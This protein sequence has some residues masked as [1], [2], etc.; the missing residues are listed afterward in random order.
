MS[1]TTVAIVGGG[2]S[3]LVAAISAKRMGAKVTILERNPRVGKKILA[4]GNGRCNLTN[5]NADVPCYNGENP[6]FIYSAFSQFSVERSLEFFE[7]LGIE[8]K[9]EEEGKVYPMSDQASSVLDVLLYEVHR[10]KIEVLCDS[11]VQAIKPTK[12]GFSLDLEDGRKLSFDKV[13]LCAGGSAMPSSGSDGNGFE[14]A[15][16]LGHSTTK[17]FPALVQIMLEGDFFK[18]IDGVKFVGTV[19]VIEGKKVIA[20]DRGD[21]LFTN[22]GVSGPPILQ[23][24][25][26]ASEAR[27]FHKKRE[28]KLVLIDSLDK[29]DLRKR[30]D[31]RFR[32][33]HSKTAEESMIGLINKRL[34][35]V[36]LQEAGISDLRKKASDLSEKEKKS[37]L[38]LLTDW[39][40]VIKGT[41]GWQSSQVTAG[42]VRTADI[43]ADT[44]ESKLV[45]GLYLAGEIVDIDGRCG[46]YN[47]QWAWSSGY[48]AGQNAAYA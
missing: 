8:Y 38:D 2:A 21:V 20:N 42:G 10:L 26:K 17:I 34:I 33:A 6:K 25:R 4:T 41:K 31:R 37:L 22:Y 40:F 9:V 39:R 47:L 43:C 3:G 23:V 28:L 35:P 1:R 36:V 24:S 16:S 46:G 12:K 45:A 48:I 7:G 27:E 15:K 19:E 30:L 5:I 44:M 29:E 14:L 11:F 13:V 32:T 18:R